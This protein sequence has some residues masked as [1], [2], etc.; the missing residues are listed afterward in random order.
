[1]KILSG[2]EQVMLRR[3]CLQV[4]QP[5]FCQVIPY[6]QCFFLCVCGGGWYWVR[7]G[8]VRTEAGLFTSHLVTRLHSVGAEGETSPAAVGGR[9]MKQKQTPSIPGYCFI[10][11]ETNRSG[12][13]VGEKM[14]PLSGGVGAGRSQ[15]PLE[16]H[17]K[18][19]WSEVWKTKGG[20]WR[21]KHMREGRRAS[22]RSSGSI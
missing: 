6:R 11:Y 17:E 21:C 19:L 13:S 4:Q 7:C 5:V 16:N 20:M 18:W 3:R 22:W 9:H 10:K 1:M 15:K 12:G 2:W 14:L 8:H